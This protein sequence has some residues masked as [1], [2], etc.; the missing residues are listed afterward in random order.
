MRLMS[1]ARRLS[2]N[3]RAKRFALFESLVAELP[4]PLRILDIGGT[5]GFW[6][7]AGYADSARAEITL[8]NIYDQEQVHDNVRPHRG[9]A[10]NLR[11]FSDGEFDLVFSNSVIE[12][13]FRFENQAAMAE[14]VRRLAQRYWVQTPNYWFPLEPHFHFLG[15]QWLPSDIRVEILR[16]RDCGW[17][18]RTPDR[19]KARELVDEVQLLSRRQLESLFPGARIEAER[20]AGLVKSWMVIGGFSAPSGSHPG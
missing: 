2:E 8:V 12:H 14:E 5:T 7:A 10:T 20:F 17:R 4:R 16:R 6:E 13:L 19:E 15:W 18:G 11:E 1:V 3:M 9:D